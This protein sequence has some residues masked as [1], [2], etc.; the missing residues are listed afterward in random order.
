MMERVEARGVP[1]EPRAATARRRVLTLSSVLVVIVGALVL[2]SVSAVGETVEFPAGAQASPRA[3]AAG[4][5]GNVWYGLYEA[6]GRVT[7]D[8]VVTEFPVPGAT[9]GPGRIVAGPDGNLWF[10]GPYAQQ[11]GRMTT[12]GVATIFPTGA[13]GT[14][15]DIAVGGDGNL[16][17]IL[18]DSDSIGRITTSGV[19]TMFPKPVTSASSRDA[20]GVAQYGTP[21]TAITDGPDGNLWFTERNG[22]IGRMTTAGVVT[23]FDGPSGDC[24]LVP[25][26]SCHVPLDITTGPDGNLWFTESHGF[27]GRMTTDGVITEFATGDEGAFRIAAGVDDDLWFIAFEPLAPG[28]SLPN[29]RIRHITTDGVV[30]DCGGTE[31]S[32]PPTDIAIGPDRNLWFTVFTTNQVGRRPGLCVPALAPRFTG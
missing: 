23:M 14:P 26:E 10:T 16:W 8:G 31:T 17:F 30:G 20:A 13:P 21:P 7:P 6:M 4:P 19:V 5:D 2:T 22:Q 15:I 11:I 9:S 29:G 24:G 32:G 18:Y 28:A 1:T 27:I 25:D 3:I 12:D